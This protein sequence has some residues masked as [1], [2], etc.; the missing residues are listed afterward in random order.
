MLT[1]RSQEMLDVDAAEHNS[2]AARAHADELYE[3]QRR[4]RV[5]WKAVLLAVGLFALGSA[6]LALSAMLLRRSPVPDN[7][8]P[9]LTL[10]LL[11]FVPGFYATRIAVWSYFGYPDFSFDD[12]PG[13]DD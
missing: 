3:A 11:T 7:A 10:G 12:L 5:P 1:R 8:Y 9:L 6:M 2:D 4:R 13:F